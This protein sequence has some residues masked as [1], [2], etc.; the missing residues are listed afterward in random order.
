MDTPQLIGISI[1]VGAFAL[2][3]IVVFFKSNIVLC[4]PNELV[5]IAGRQR[6]LD[7]GSIIGY[8]VLRGGRGFKWPLVESVAKLSLNSLPV[9]VVVGKA[10]CQGMIPVTIEAKA[11]VKLAGRESE[12]MDA[13]IERF[14]GKGPDAVSKTAKQSL[15]G[16]LRGVVATMT[17]EDAN[18]RRLELAKGASEQAR[19]DLSR[20]GIVLDFLQVQEVVDDHGY[21][22]AIGRKRN[23]TVQRDARIAEATADAEAR[24][25]A[26]DQGRQGRQAEIDADLQVVENENALAVKRADL[27]ATANQAEQRASLAGDIAR[28]ESQ[29]TLETKRAERNEKREEANTVVPARAKNQAQ[30][31]EAEGAAAR[32]LE[33]GKATAEAIEL[34]RA[35]WQ[36]GETR[37]LF[38]IQ[39]MPDL[40]DKVTRVVADNLRV[41]KVTILDGG[42]GAGLPNYVKNLTKSAIAML[43]Q[44]E[45]A[46]GIDIAKL[47]KG[48]KEA[49]IP[50]ELPRSRR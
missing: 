16:A 49:P 15:E 8:R 45:N 44:V 30:K 47:A 50:P 11:T 48:V 38:L 6:K 10:M 25:V 42:D 4:Q 7:D 17:P 19:G 46:T 2:M 35:Q 32:I 37:D 34:M 41:D 12:G 9:D 40:L 23:S 26:A 1:G 13:A 5:I 36:D 27:Q 24:T 3:L 21:L 33:D 20:L 29:V 14:L 22:E 31:L 18:S 28:A 39:L 43:E